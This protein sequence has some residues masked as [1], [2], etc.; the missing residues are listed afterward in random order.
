M[1]LIVV[2]LAVFLFI[3][4]SRA[5][6]APNLLVNGDFSQGITGWTLEGADRTK[7]EFF[8]VEGQDFKKALRVVVTPKA[9]D[10]RFTVKLLA[11]PPVTLQA[12]KIYRLS[13]WFRSPDHA[14]VTFKAMRGPGLK[15]YSEVDARLNGQ[16]QFVSF[17]LSPE[18]TLPNGEYAIAVDLSAR[19]ATIEIADVRM[20]EVTSLIPSAPD[21][22]KLRPEL[23]LQLPHQGVVASLQVSADGKH[24]VSGGWD[25]AIKIWDAGSTKLIRTISVKRAAY[26]V[27]ISPDGRLIAAAIWFENSI[28]IFEMASGRQ[29]AALSGHSDRVHDIAFVD[30]NRLVSASQDST[31]RVWNLNNG[32]TEQVLRGHTG[33]VN[34]I[35]IAASHSL[36][37]S[38]SED[39]TAKLWDITGGQ[40]LKDF[41][42]DAA[43]RSVVISP[44]RKL[45]AVAGANKFSLFN[46]KNATLKQ[47]FEVTTFPNLKVGDA[48]SNRVSFSPDGNYLIGC[49][50]QCGRIY[51]WHLEN[52]LA[53]TPNS[54]GVNTHDAVFSPD[55]EAVFSVNTNVIIKWDKL[56]GNV[57]RQFGHSDDSNFTVIS[58]S[59]NNDYVGLS[60]SNSWIAW[61]LKNGTMETAV[62]GN[63]RHRSSFHPHDKKLLLCGKWLGKGVLNYD[64]ESRSSTFEFETP[65]RQYMSASISLNGALVA[66]NSVGQSAIQIWDYA[67]KKLL[68]EL[69]AHT[70]PVWSLEFSPT[71][72]KLVSGDAG[73]TIK[74]W[75]TNTWQ[76]ICSVSSA[77][78]SQITFSR[79]GKYLVCQTKGNFE[80]RNSVSGAVIR[81]LKA[82][83]NS[84]L[85][86]LAPDSK[87]YAVR[88]YDQIDIMDVESGRVLNK[89]DFLHG[90]H[91]FQWSPDGKRFLVASSGG[92]LRVYEFPSW[93]LIATMVVLPQSDS[94]ISPEWITVTPEGYYNCSSEA[95]RFMQVNLGAEQYPAECFAAKY[96]RPD[97][98]ERALRGEK[99]PLP[100]EFKGAFPPQVWVASGDNKYENGAATVTLHVQDDSDV[101]NVAFF[102]NGSKV[103]A[104][105]AE[106]KPDARPL[107]ADGRPLPADGRA[108]V[109]EGRAIPAEGRPLVADGRPMVADGRTMPVKVARTMTFRVPVPAT[110]NAKVQVLAF[111]DDGLQ[112]PR[113][114]LLFTP[115]EKTPATPLPAQGAGGRLLGLCV[116]VS[117]YQNSKLNLKFA[118]KD[119]VVLADSLNAQR[120]LYRA[121]Q[122]TAL[123]DDKATREGVKTALDNLIT[124]TTRNDTVVLLLAGHG[125]RGPENLTRRRNFFFATH[126]LEPENIVASALPWSEVVNRLGKLSA[127]S[128]RVIVL[129]DACHSGSAAGNEELVKEILNAN[130][131]VMVLASSRG[132]EISLESAEWEHGAFSKAIIEAVQ[133]KAAGDDRAVSVWDFANYV[134][135]RVA[136]LT[137][138]RQHPQVPFLSDF[139]TDAA[140]ATVDGV[141][142]AVTPRVV[143][144]V[145]PE[146]KPETKNSLPKPALQLAAGEI[147]LEGIVRAIDLTK[148]TLTIEVQ[149]FALPDGKT[150]KL[151]VTRSK[152]VF[153]AHNALVYRQSDSTKTIDMKDIKIG[154]RISAVG[155]DLGSGQLLPAR[156]VAIEL[157]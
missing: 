50:T 5:N 28:P 143:P 38:V 77:K 105:P 17:G 80:L 146:V 117:Q 114:E 107:T 78:N 18:T 124:Q 54:H 115:G 125:W 81:T 93:R 14:D 52:G 113:Q 130:A 140:I 96:Y 65:D 21:V 152:A 40:L 26:R 67:S 79:D 98:V 45:L 35:S 129:L 10:Q 128:K 58:Q 131:G 12:S 85:M 120:G 76:V 148:R 64:L 70:E 66:I 9:G 22:R 112:S 108:L 62:S 139:D 59:P 122:V 16:W 41:S 73:G 150:S 126:E 156:A 110:G 20:Q 23:D 71:E 24:L 145:A 99:V 101:R 147:K 34:S 60:Y 57:I 63:D 33:P 97:M 149:S 154:Q 42:V 100:E 153:V 19:P 88:T 49:S 6:D 111:D 56:T 83:A 11:R 138:D 134:K 135:K 29:V 102:V 87:S 36:L 8:R 157:P 46:V 109:A 27:K 92:H 37:A 44:D 82:G 30:S 72:N 68:R 43:V 32:R 47:T 127:K 61:N 119:A 116:G 94:A 141:P 144:E 25:A 55:G 137:E 132:S 89:F 104:T 75:D 39:N 123:T 136:T 142:L 95:A 118:H 84:N 51:I 1:R 69:N 13:A 4:V 15:N 133:G 3:A 90:L 74:I 31:I 155:T 121:A 53:V 106:L 7:S 2:Y 103:E 151:A 48:Y 86:R 91:N